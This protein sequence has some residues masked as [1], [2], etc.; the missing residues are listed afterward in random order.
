MQEAKW[1]TD[2]GR[3]LALTR[4]PIPVQSLSNCVTLR[5]YPPLPSLISTPCKL[6][7]LT[8][9][10][11]PAALRALCEQTGVRYP[12]WRLAQSG[13]FI[14]WISVLPLPFPRMQPGVGF[15]GSIQANE[16]IPFRLYYV[17]LS[18]PPLAPE[19]WF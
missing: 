17:I 4:V 2:H 13:G 10:S 19:M 7:L 9:P 14:S 5:I 16:V 3:A 11:P 15:S 6:E 12:G 18:N 8:R 1:V